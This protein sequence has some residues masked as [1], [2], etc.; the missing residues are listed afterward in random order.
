M[1]VLWVR[2]SASIG[3]I[4]MRSCIASARLDPVFDPLV[5]RDGDDDDE[6]VADQDARI[7]GMG[8]AHA[9]LSPISRAA[10]RASN[11]MMPVATAD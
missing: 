4:S 2:K 7:A 5:E 1:P 6:A 11:S 9:S 8:F 3:T 10:R